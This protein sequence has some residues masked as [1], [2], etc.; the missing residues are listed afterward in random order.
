MLVLQMQSM[1][2]DMHEVADKLFLGSLN[3]AKNTNALRE[4]GITHILSVEYTPLEPYLRSGR[5]NVE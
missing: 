5:Y 2:Q 1:K 4:R 3:A